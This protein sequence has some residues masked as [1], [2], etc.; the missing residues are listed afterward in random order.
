MAFLKAEPESDKP[1]PRTQA[2]SDVMRRTLFGEV[3]L[4]KR[5]ESYWPESG[6]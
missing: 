3:E 1:S 6:P 4:R 5:W 2:W